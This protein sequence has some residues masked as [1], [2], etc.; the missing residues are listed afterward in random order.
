MQVFLN[1]NLIS[2]QT[3]IK[4]SKPG[5]YSISNTEWSF[6]A[7][8]IVV[9]FE[10]IKLIPNGKNL[11]KQTHRKNY[12]SKILFQTKINLNQEEVFLSMERNTLCCKYSL[13][14]F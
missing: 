12:P 2:F 9:P 7:D 13:L 1:N 14:F 5:F 4:Q 11:A 10:K 8:S 6:E 3:Q